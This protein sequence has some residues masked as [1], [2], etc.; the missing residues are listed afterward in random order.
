MPAGRSPGGQHETAMKYDTLRAYALSLADVSEEPHHHFGS[1]R[2]RGRIFV[3][4]PPEQEHVHVFVSEPQREVALALHPEFAEKL[5][6]GGKVVG[7]T[8]TLARAQAAAV[9]ELVRQAWEHQ[10]AKPRR[11]R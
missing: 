4:V 9:R 7:L 3:T 1:F 6:W 10:S 11:A 8:L 2:V 5:L